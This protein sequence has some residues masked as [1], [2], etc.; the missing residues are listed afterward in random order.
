M[1]TKELA[2]AIKIV[3]VVFAMGLSSQSSLLLR[4]RASRPRGS[5]S[6]RSLGL[7]GDDLHSS[8]SVAG[9]LPDAGTGRTAGRKREQTLRLTIAHLNNAT[10]SIPAFHA[11]LRPGRRPEVSQARLDAG[12]IAATDV[13]THDDRIH[14]RARRD[15]HEAPTAAARSTCN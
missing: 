3:P 2:V 8:R 12:R 15:W 14:R 7:C 5:A 10:A 11:R 6:S 13:S 4:R 9:D 1:L